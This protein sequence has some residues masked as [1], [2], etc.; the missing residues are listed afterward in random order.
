MTKIT[1]EEKEM[2]KYFQEETKFWRKIK[3]LLMNVRK[4]IANINTQ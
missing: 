4:Q 2:L 1:K 3:E